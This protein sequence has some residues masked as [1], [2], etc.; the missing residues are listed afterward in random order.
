MSERILAIADLL[1]GAACADGTRSGDEDV[2]V[3]KL[4]ADL[5]G[6]AALPAEV[7]AHLRAFDPK[8]ID[9]A[10][11]AASLA[12]DSAVGKRKLV[13][14]VAAVRDADESIDL[15]EDDY[16]RAVGR[17][18]G[19]PDEEM[20]ELVLEYTVEELSAKVKA[21]RPPPMPKS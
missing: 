1:L 8:S 2:V 21:M 17:A 9:P 14:L 5:I 18:L 6:S 13:E 15:A 20:K 10:K 16:L 7:R 11:V 12:D 19:I 3:E 4:L